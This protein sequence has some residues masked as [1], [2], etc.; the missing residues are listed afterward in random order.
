MAGDGIGSDAEPADADE[1]GAEDAVPATIA[2]GPSMV[3]LISAPQTASSSPADS[4]RT[5]VS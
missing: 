5:P 3:T 4:A 1:L 2:T